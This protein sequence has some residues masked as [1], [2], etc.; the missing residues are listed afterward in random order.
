VKEKLIKKVDS[1]VENFESRYLIIVPI[2][3]LLSTTS[4]IKEAI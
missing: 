2:F 1:G 3:S 4:F